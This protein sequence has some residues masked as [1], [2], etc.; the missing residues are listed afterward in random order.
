MTMEISPSS[1]AAC[2]HCGDPALAGSPFCCRG[3]ESVYTLLQS[4]GLQHFYELKGS[5]AFGKPKKI[6][7]AAQYGSE[8][9]G[10]RASLYIE[11]IH[12]LGC[13]WLLERLPDLEPRI[14]S[15][16]L[17][18]AHNI[19]EVEIQAD[20]IRWGEVMS[21]I[22]Q[23]G[24]SAKAVE[25]KNEAREADLRR[26]LVRL[27]VAAFSA[28]NVMLLAVALYAGAATQ[29]AGLFRW[30]SALLAAPALVFSAWP[31]YRSAFLPLRRGRI[32]VDLAIALAILAGIVLSARSLA[33]G[34]EEIYFDSLSML[35]FLLLSSRYLL[36]RYRSSLSREA[37]F[38]SYFSSER[39]ARLSPSPGIASAES[40][41]PGEIFLLQSGQTLPVDSILLSAEAHFD[42]SL[43]TGESLPVKSIAR[44]SVD[45]GARLL[46]ESA[47]CEAKRAAAQSRLSQ[48]LEQIHSFQLS[49]IPSLDFA[50]RMGKYFVVVVLLLAA[51]TV[52]WLPNEEGV[53]RALALVIVTCP[54]VLAFAVP[55]AFSRALQQAARAGILFRQ[56]EK[57][58]ALASIRR[59]Y[60]DKTGTL[61][62]GQ[63]RVKE[64]VTLSGEA[65]ADAKAVAA[66]EAKSRHPVARAL[67]RHLSGVEAPPAEEIAEMPGRGIKGR[68]QGAL[69]EIRSAEGKSGDNEI[70]LSCEGEIRARIVLGDHPRPDAR[71][72]ISALKEDGLQLTILSGDSEANVAAAAKELGIPE[73]RS[74]LL[75]EEKAQAV[76]A[77]RF[78]AMVGD[79]ANDAVAF[80]A[81]S[82]GIAVQGAMDLSLKNSDLALPA[83]GIAALLPAIRL[84]RSTMRLVRSN[85]AIT[86]LYNLVAGFLALSGRMSPLLAA[87]IM[88]AS[89]FSVFALTQWRTRGGNP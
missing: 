9:A 87:I 82:I 69:W 29:W 28:G 54:C 39:Y 22:A 62:T 19:L 23:L 38:L 51:A 64:W 40:L 81:A 50:E 30:L 73:W 37:P 1:S 27:G 12:C 57:I 89:A 8:E 72:I 88:P 59:I 34:G 58:E 26:Q 42:L 67:L 18:L 46:S 76:K 16:R 11:G 10:A 63:Y 35:V 3:C 15:S 5:Y 65:E 43:L 71:E 13:L 14:L 6:V 2:L 4:R 41:K 55:L 56:P 84:S 80:Q 66:L 32:S 75:P 85:F 79:G 20:R 68:V 33:L 70:E 53:R 49:R 7:A 74:R 60:L 21:L 31:L 83:G 17:D 36:G 61:T 24:Y 52:A 48:I 47:R 44:E 45:A 86:L 25:N 78:A 77:G